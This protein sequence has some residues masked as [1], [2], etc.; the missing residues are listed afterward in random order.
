MAALRIALKDLRQRLRDRSAYLWGIVA[1]L[2]LAAIFSLLFSG[3][4]DN[5]L[6]VSFGVA[7]DDGGPTARLFVDQVLAPLGERGV[8]AVEEVASAELVRQMAADGK[9]D[10]AFVIPAGFSA[11]AEGGGTT[12]IEVVANVNSPIAGQVARSVAGKFVGEIN[13]VGVSLGTYFTALGRSP[14]AGEAEALVADARAVPD[15]LGLVEDTKNSKELS[16][17]TYYSAA[18][19]ILF[20]F[21]TVQFGVLGLL[22]ERE[23]GTLGRL[24]AAPISRRSIVAG[25]ALTSFVLGVVS[26][27]V[28]AVG[29]TVLL[30]ASWGNSLGV[31]VMVLAGVIAAMG[32]MFVVAAFAR[33]AE[34]AGNLQVVIG[35]VLAMLGGSF[36][37]VS[38]MGGFIGKLSLITPHAWFLRGLGDLAAGGGVSAVF[39]AALYVA[40]FGLVTGGLAQL[41]MAKVLAP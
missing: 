35:F 29:T 21:L 26:M 37:P 1:P 8:F 25:K 7:D 32:V 2:G 28:L 41:R 19:G 20:L 23:N 17:G 13:G 14:E 38:Q 9:V 5:A 22:E 15:P 34:Q 18:M 39:P 3:I 10:A 4:A 30:G 31:A 40:L 24:L 33:T 16:S 36:F 6:N 12:A 11:A 27:A